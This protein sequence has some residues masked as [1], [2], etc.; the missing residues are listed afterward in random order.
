[1]CPKAV[2]A[3]SEL[4][5]EGT[6][7]VRPPPP[8]PHPGTAK[9]RITLP[10]AA[11]GAIVRQ[12]AERSLVRAASDEALSGD[13]APG[14][15]TTKMTSLSRENRLVR[16][17]RLHSLS[18]V[19]PLGAFLVLHLWVNAWAMQ[20]ELRYDAVVRR[21]QSVPGLLFFETVLIYVPLLFHAG[22][23]IWTMRTTSSVRRRGKYDAPWAVRLQRTSGLVTLAFLGYH[24]FS[25]RAEVALGTMRPADFYSVLTDTL[26]STTSLGIPRSAVLY[27][28]GLAAASYH[29]AGGLLG[30]C[31]TWGIAVT[32]GRYR[33][34]RALSTAVGLSLFLLGARTIVYFA[35][36]AAFPSFGSGAPS[37]GALN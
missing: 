9:S 6:G 33:V 26:G 36:G 20:G 11:I 34:A 15:S 29:L 5:T 19:L 27:F 1:M 8:A 18:G 10:V 37:A 31:F 13:T 16:L 35:T 21:I 22:Y 14:I 17:R 12:V 23:G 24:L 25:I 28:V 3:P 30:F 7:T 4:A 2:C 32:E